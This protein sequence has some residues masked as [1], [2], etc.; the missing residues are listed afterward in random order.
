MNDEQYQSVRLS[1]TVGR[2]DD[3]PFWERYFTLC[4][5]PLPYEKFVLPIRNEIPHFED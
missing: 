5:I 3:M 2:L 4:G 1:S